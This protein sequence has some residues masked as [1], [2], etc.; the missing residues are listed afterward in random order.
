MDDHSGFGQIAADVVA[1]LRQDY[2]TAPIL[3]FPVR[4]AH[5][6]PSVAQVKS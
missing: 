3:V 6:A 2:P 4:P 5:A 1:E